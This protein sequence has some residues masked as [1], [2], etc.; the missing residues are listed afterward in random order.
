MSRTYFYTR[1]STKKQ[2]IS[3][4]H[5]EVRCHEHVDRLGTLPPHAGTFTDA[6]TSGTVPLAERE[7]GRA[8]LLTVQTGDY[9]VVDALDRLGRDYLDQIQSVRQLMKR[10]VNMHI[11]D[12]LILAMLDPEDPQSEDLLMQMAAQSHR[13]RRTIAARTKRAIHARRA[14]GFQTGFGKPFGYKEVPNPRYKEGMSTEAAKAVGGRHL[15][16]EDREE[17]EFFTL[18][19]ERWQ[20]GDSIKAIQR[21]YKHLPGCIH[22]YYRLRRCLLAEQDKRLKEAQRL[23]RQR[24]F[25]GVQG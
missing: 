7:A 13:E 2:D 3:P 10:G 25:A 23:E 6:A 22:S 4:A 12:L 19:W 16:V 17:K 24:V 18:A 21:K 5:Q 15:L 8:L 20:A 11:L 14:I 1:A 9:L